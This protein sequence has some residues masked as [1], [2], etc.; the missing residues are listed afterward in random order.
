MVDLTEISAIVAAADVLV[1][2]VYYILDM[3]I[4]DQR[5]TF[6]FGVTRPRYR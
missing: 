6:T 4:L 2:V 1:G 3:R 5:A